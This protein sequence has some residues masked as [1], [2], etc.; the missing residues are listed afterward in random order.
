MNKLIV[1][2]CNCHKNHIYTLDDNCKI[3]K[4]VATP[5]C[6]RA[7]ISAIPKILPIGYRIGRDFSYKEITNIQ[8]LLLAL[9]Q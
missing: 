3:V 6:P 8:S 2:D 7:M 5:T 4:I 1:L 9:T